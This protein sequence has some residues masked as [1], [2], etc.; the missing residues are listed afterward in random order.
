MHS[1]LTRLA[2]LV[3]VLHTAVAAFVVLGLPVIWIGNWK[4]WVWV[5]KL[6]FRL[7][8]LGTIGFVV[9]QSL[10]GMVCPLT[11]L[12]NWL[13]TLAGGEGPGPSFIEYWFTRLLFYQ[14]PTE[15]FTLAY[16]LFGLAVAWTWWKF[17]PKA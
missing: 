10:L 17:P 6:W 11:I 1:L 5:N 16:T 7:L 9:V 8:H 4:S 3:L 12:E 2:D 13:R 14:A 15:V